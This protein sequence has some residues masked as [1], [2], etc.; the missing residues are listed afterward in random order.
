MRDHITADVHSAVAVV[1]LF[2][3]HA[4]SLKERRS[5]VTRAVATLKNTL[6]ASVAEVAGHELWQRCV[7]G[8]AV[9]EPT[10]TGVDRSL[11]QIQPLLEQ[12]VRVT[13]LRIVVEHASVTY[14]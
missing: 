7:L 3:P 1:D 11:A 12:D 2:I 14:P 4:A 9:C 13:V 5:V 6:G 8:V 10:P